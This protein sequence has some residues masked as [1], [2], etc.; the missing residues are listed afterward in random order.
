MEVGSGLAPVLL[1]VGLAFLVPMVLTRFPQLRIPVVVGEILAGM[2]I[3]RSGLDL[4]PEN[5]TLEVLA[6]L[7]FAFLMFLSG[8]E[9]D[10]SMLSALNRSGQRGRIHPIV[11]GLIILALTI[12]IALSVAVVLSRLGLVGSPW[13][14]ALILSTTSLGIVLPVLREHSLSSTLY[15]QT[16]LLAALIA[17][18]V[19][20]VLITVVVAILSGG[21][22]LEVL[23]VGV[24]VLIFLL[25]ARF[26]QRISRWQ[27]LRHTLDDLAHTAV[28]I[29][30]RGALAVMFAFV[31]L[32]EVLGAEVILGAFLA[33]ALLAL[34]S[35]SD[36]SG[37]IEARHKL[38]AIGFGFIIPIF[39]I[40]VG[41][42]FDLPAL[43]SSASALILFP[44]LLLAAYA[45][46]MLPA[47]ILR[48]SFSGRQSLAA[49]VLLSSRLSLIVAASAIGLRLGLISE[50]LNA[51]IVLIAIVTSTLSP[52]IFSRLLPADTREE[53][54]HPLLIVGAGRTGL[55]VAQRLA[56]MHEPLRMIDRE[57]S[58]VESAAQLGFQVVLAD[59]ATAEGLLGAGIE[60]ARGLA[61]TTGDD[62]YNLQVCRLARST[63]GKETIIAYVQDARR[64]RQFQEAGAHVVNPSMA[65]A[66][67]IDGLLRF[68]D[69]Y[70]LLTSLEDDKDVAE[71][72]VRNPHLAGR[73]LR[74]LPM[75]GDVLVLA[76]RR[77]GELFVPHG[78]SQLEYGDHVT[79]LGTLESV[80]EA[81]S[82][83]Q[84]S[85]GAGSEIT[86][87]PSGYLSGH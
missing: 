19:T 30:V 68:P 3:G 64:L 9:I 79:L 85:N 11:T 67:V 28:Q 36:D 10:F 6:A 23:L 39:F 70:Y 13:L 33:G 56:R 44:V 84:R 71:I 29:K 46:K 72:E 73:R 57:P 12:G 75:P 60:E 77:Q 5:A 17:D 80:A 18:F 49:G 76:V 37:D 48:Q 31:V 66:S 51:D 81:S 87:S 61:V 62:E 35:S 14:L 22:T 78:H 47:M 50:A 38:D 74:D 42:R 83:L 45:V 20:M 7:G 54:V 21:I 55:L 15:G 4:V 25:A 63:F 41:V 27:P 26:A 32:S 53:V 65:S 58:R 16:I 43:L 69:A 82:W 8:L 24:L 1:V 2:V 40:M 86:A 59:A 52:A 34:I